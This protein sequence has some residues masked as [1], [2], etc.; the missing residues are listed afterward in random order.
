VQGLRAFVYLCLYLIHEL[1]ER[2]CS[3]CSAFGAR[4]GENHLFTVFFRGCDYGFV[5]VKRAYEVELLRAHLARDPD[6]FRFCLI[7]GPALY[8]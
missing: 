4:G 6:C 1:Q 8:A 3:F 7:I 2:I 5:E